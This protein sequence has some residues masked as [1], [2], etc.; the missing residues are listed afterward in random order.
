MLEVGFIGLL[1]N[2]GSQSRDLDVGTTDQIELL[3]GRQKVLM[4][5]VNNL[6]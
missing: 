6:P 4:Q 2:K 5:M 3:S 1:G